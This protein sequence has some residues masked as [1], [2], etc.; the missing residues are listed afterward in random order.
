[1]PNE[2][3]PGQ[4]EGISAQG[5]GSAEGGAHSCTFQWHS[6]KKEEGK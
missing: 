6:V 3:S 2:G 5:P 4:L 1:M